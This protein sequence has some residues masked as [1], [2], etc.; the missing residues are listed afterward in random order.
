MASFS[1][2][3]VLLLVVIHPEIG[4]CRILVYDFVE[5]ALFGC[6]VLPGVSMPPCERVSI[7]S[8]IPP[9]PPLLIYLPAWA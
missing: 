9:F 1:F 4:V 6:L 3:S 2:L 8:S 7:P 5:M